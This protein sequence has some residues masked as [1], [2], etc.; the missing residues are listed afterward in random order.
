MVDAVCMGEEPGTV[1]ALELH[2]L[3][4]SLFTTHN[5]SL[6]LWADLLDCDLLLL[7]AEPRNTGFGER[8][9]VEIGKAS[10]RIADLLEELLSG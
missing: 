3:A 10:D 6:V 1:S 2:E 7:C 5:P 4:D 8:M 9:S